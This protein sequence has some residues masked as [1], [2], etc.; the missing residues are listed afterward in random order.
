MVS[1]SPERNL[2]STS[3]T[4]CSSRVRADSACAATCPILLCAVASLDCSCIEYRITRVLIFSVNSS[5]VPRAI[6]TAGAAA[7]LDKAQNN[8][9][10]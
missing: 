10:R 2:S 5:T 3:R 6:P 7:T 1:P 4:V 8:G 9:I